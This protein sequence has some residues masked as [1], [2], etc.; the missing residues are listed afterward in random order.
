[1]AVYRRPGMMPREPTISALTCTVSPKMFTAVRGRPC[2]PAADFWMSCDTVVTTGGATGST[3]GLF[4]PND[5]TSAFASN[6]GAG[7]A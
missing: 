4:V 7:N 3:P 1:V 6:G 2:G 5:A